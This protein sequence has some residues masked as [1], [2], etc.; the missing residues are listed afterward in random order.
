VAKPNEFNYPQKT[1][2]SPA[3]LKLDL[4]LEKVKVDGLAIYG[5]DIYIDVYASGTSKLTF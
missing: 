3:P 2:E 4:A 5:G 1:A